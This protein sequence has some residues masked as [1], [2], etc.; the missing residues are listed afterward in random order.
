MKNLLV[1]CFI[2]I[3]ELFIPVYAKD[4]K[5]IQV[6]DVHLTQHNS[7]SLRNFVQ[8]INTKYED[9][10]FIIFTGDNIDKANESDLSLL[11]NIIKNLKFKC[12]ILVGN[13]D[14]Y[15]NHK[16]THDKYMQMV[17]KT[18]GPYHS[19]KPN[20][21]FK[22]DNFVFI[23]MNGVKEVI[24]GPNGY[25]KENEL[26]WLDRMLSKYSN[27]KVVIFQHFPL[28]DTA[29][30]SHSLY[31]KEQY[32]EVL[33]KHNNVIA[34]ISGHYHHNREEFCDNIYNVVTKNFA[35]NR[36]YKLIEIRD[37]FVYTQ[38]IDNNDERYD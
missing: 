32:L 23:V 28:L 17:R 6:T 20:Y 36:Y 35:D 11:I 29:T 21:I 34:I 7:D 25:Y 26:V 38:L 4:I 18:L 1:F 16:M 27:K 37:G 14:L 3:I 12:Y 10:D 8:D 5:F 13:H 2:I 9:I 22:K 31:K 15:K 19:S 24:P 33:K 30:K